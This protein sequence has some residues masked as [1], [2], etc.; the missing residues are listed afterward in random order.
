MW[1]SGAGYNSCKSC[2]KDCETCSDEATCEEC[3]PGLGFFT[4]S[5]ECMASCG[6]GQAWDE[7]GVCKIIE[8]K[9]EIEEEE[10]EEEKEEEEEP[11]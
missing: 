7:N 2:I 8:I 11:T 3:S 10:E 5:K 1:N 6:Y 9:E 4:G